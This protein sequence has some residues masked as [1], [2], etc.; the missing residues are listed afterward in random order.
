MLELPQGTT[1]ICKVF[2]A[3]PLLAQYSKSEL[4]EWEAKAEEP[5]NRKA[6][7]NGMEEKLR[8]LSKSKLTVIISESNIWYG[9]YS[10]IGSSQ[11]FYKYTLKKE[12]STELLKY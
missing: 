4:S 5:T 1:E 6:H 9:G 12:V 10:R 11:T 2:P 8:M 3:L 7:E